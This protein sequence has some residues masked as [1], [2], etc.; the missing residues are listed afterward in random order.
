M[1][2]AVDNLNVD[3]FTP[4][5]GFDILGLEILAL[6]GKLGLAWSEVVP[7]SYIQTSQYKRGILTHSFELPALVDS[8]DLGAPEEDAAISY[9]T[10]HA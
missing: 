2:V 9:S 5:V 4:D 6:S 7:V 1:A 10:V 3:M 8:R